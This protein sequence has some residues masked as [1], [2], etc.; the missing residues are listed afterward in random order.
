MRIAETL[1][2]M[3][4]Q[5]E[6]PNNEAILQADNLDLSNAL[7]VLPRVATAVVEAAAILKQCAAEVDAI[8]G[9]RHLLV[10]ETVQLLQALAA[11][12]LDEHVLTVTLFDGEEKLGEI[13]ASSTDMLNKLNSV[14]LPED[15]T[16]TVSLSDVSN[17]PGATVD[18]VA[19]LA[20]V[21]DSSADASLQ[22][23]A[24]VIDELLLTISAPS[25]WADNFKAAQSKKI[26]EIKQLY[27]EPGEKIHASYHAEDS[28]KAIEK[29]EYNKE[30]RILE[31]PLNTRYCPDHAGTPIAR[32][33]NNQWQC[34]L[35]H[36]IYD[37]EAGYTDEHGRKHA[38]GGAPAIAE[39]TKMRHDYHSI[40]DTRPDRLNKMR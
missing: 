29:S 9:K 17:V 5:L 1:I 33:G 8:E 27:H 24:S 34:A 23:Q 10:G 12:P 21:L 32:I 11:T 28:K 15:L 22:K 7:E 2:A 19:R 36:K 4:N 37:V 14:E 40:F 6:N 3:A 31:G 18:K 20:H 13:T 16:A 38:P 26:D 35:D 39:M 25:D 30:Y